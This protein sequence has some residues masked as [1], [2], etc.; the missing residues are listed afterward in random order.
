M[1]Y[2]YF[3]YFKNSFKIFDNYNKNFIAKKTSEINGLTWNLDYRKQFFNFFKFI[4]NFSGN[5]TKLILNLLLSIDK[6]KTS[7]MKVLSIGPRTEGEIFMIRNFG[8]KKENI[9][10]VDL[11]S[12]SPLIKLGDMH[13]LP[14]DDNA[15]DMI[16]SGWTLTYSE[17]NHK[18]ISEIIRV[19]KNNCLVGIGFSYLPNIN[20]H[21]DKIHNSK[22]LFKYFGNN[23][24]DVYFK[25]HPNDDI[26]DRNLS[27]K[28]AIYLLKI[29][30]TL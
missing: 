30:K 8:F 4:Q 18:A 25:Y 2:L 7:Q 10:A 1:R 22:V 12:Y 16:I 9:F 19:G 24:G 14:F 21:K 20:F 5:R 17:N 26:E 13:N 27:S 3:V 29:K 28:R 11:S 23:I 15:F 6:I